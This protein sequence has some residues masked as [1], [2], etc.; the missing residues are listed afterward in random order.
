MNVIELEDDIML[1]KLIALYRRTPTEHPKKVNVHT[2]FVKEMTK[3]KGERTVHFPLRFINKEK[4]NIIH[5][6]RLLDENG[7]FQLD[8]LLLTRFF[9]LILEVKNWYGTLLFDRSGQVIRIGD[10]QIEEGFPNPISQLYLQKF[11]LQRWFSNLG[12]NNLP[13]V[14]FVVIS[15]PS[16]ILKTEPPS[17]DIQKEIIRSEQLPVKINQLFDHY[18]DKVIT[19]EAIGDISTKII[20]A[21]KPRNEDVL[22]KYEISVKDLRKGVICDQCS[23]NSMMKRHKYWRCNNCKFQSETVYL[24]A[25]NDYRLLIGNKLKNEDIRKFLLID[26]P[27]I[28]KRLMLKAGFKYEGIKKGRVYN[29]DMLSSQSFIS[30]ENR[31]I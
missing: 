23:V 16:T 31:K 22:L 11:R 30:S 18:I 6:T 27:Y 5:S 10:N 15:F 29:L 25:L 20:Q 1:N 7:F 26:S 13:I 24:E 14:G 19:S 4:V 28:V 21:H 17:I 8:T 2:D 9:A 12:V 3:K